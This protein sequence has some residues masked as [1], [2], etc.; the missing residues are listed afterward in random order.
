M[1]N[2]YLRAEINK[3]WLPGQIHSDPICI[4]NVFL[5]HS[6]RYLFTYC[7]GNFICTNDDNMPYTKELTDSNLC[8]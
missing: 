6:L 2:G 8:T 7:Q 3:L 4:N 1:Q 5:E